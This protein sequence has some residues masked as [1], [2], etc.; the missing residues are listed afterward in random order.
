M[1]KQPLTITIAGKDFV[2]GEI[3][4]CLFHPNISSSEYLSPGFL[5]NLVTAV[6]IN[7]K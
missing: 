6:Y 4:K 7:S 1:L 2:D 5:N 3:Y